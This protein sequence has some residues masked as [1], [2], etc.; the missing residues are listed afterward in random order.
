MNEF[1]INILGG[2]DCMEAKMNLPIG[3]NKLG[4]SQILCDPSLCWQQSHYIEVAQAA[5]SSSAIHIQ[6]CMLVS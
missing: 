5:I 2:F 4:C 6:L 1:V 3:S